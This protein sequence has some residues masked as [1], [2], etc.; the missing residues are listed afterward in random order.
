MLLGVMEALETQML[1][2]CRRSLPKRKLT[3]MF[4]QSEQIKNNESDNKVVW[5]ETGK[6]AKSSESKKENEKVS[7]ECVCDT[8]DKIFCFSFL[9]S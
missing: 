3:K 1:C 9:K 7:L 5:D 8:D 2:I 6:S 4:S